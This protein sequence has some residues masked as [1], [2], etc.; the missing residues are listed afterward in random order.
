MNKNIHYTATR[1]TCE[2]E[3]DIYNY[4]ESQLAKKLVQKAT[5]GRKQYF[6]YGNDS[7]STA[8]QVAIILS[9]SQLSE[10]GNSI[11]SVDFPPFL[12]SLPASPAI[13]SAMA[14][15]TKLACSVVTGFK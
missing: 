5:A 7:D 3:N 11:S 10:L 9:L 12:N 15:G 14:L 2:L 13:T 4:I 1:I 8:M 6:Y